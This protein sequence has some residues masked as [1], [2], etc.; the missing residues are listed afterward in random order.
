MSSTTL[1]APETVSAPPAAPAGATFVVFS[2][3]L[4]RQLLAF[5][6]AT[7]AAAA[8]RPV[9]M[10]F[11][12]WGLAALRRRAPSRGKGFLDRVFGWLLPCGTG[13]LPLSRLQ[14]AGFGPVLL[15][16]R[17]RRRGQA[18]LEQLLE[19]AQ[20]LGVRFVVCEA[21]LGVLGLR[22]EDLLPGVELAGAASCFAAAA[23]SDVAM[24]V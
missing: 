1:V 21:S 11:A 15:R 5:T 17:M 20:A 12:F 7:T 3:E 10:F 9:T 19:Q 8:G 18:S 13:A 23:A 22:P 4:D 2:S 14:F 16:W 6:L 24:V